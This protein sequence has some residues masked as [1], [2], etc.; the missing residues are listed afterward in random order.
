[1]RKNSVFEQVQQALGKPYSDLEFLL[2]CFEEVLVESNKQDIIQFIPWLNP[3]ACPS[4]KILLGHDYGHMLSMCFQLLNIVEVNGAVQG[5]RK[6]EEHHMSEVNGLWA[7]NFKVLKEKG[8]SE[9]QIM[10]SFQD[11]RIEPVL[12]AHPTEAKRS[13]VL[14]EYRMLY[15][16]MVKRENHMYTRIEQDDIREDIKQILHRL[17]NIDEIY[18]EKPQIESE[19]DNVIYYLKDVLPEVV[20]LLDKRLKQAWRE[21]GY[22]VDKLDQVDNIPGL[23]FGN[24][25]GGDRDG[26]PLVTAETTQMA[27]RKLRV[28]AFMIIKEALLDLAQKLSIYVTADQLSMDFNSRIAQLADEIGRDGGKVLKEHKNETFTAYILLLLNKIPIDL[29]LELNFKLLDKKGSYKNSLE[30]ID[31]INLL[32]Y[33]LI[34]F[35]ASKLA[36][37]DVGRFK[38]LLQV[39]GFHMARLDIRQNSAYHERA[40]FQLI[41]ASSLNG[42]DDEQVI[43]PEKKKKLIDKELTINRPFLV[44]H[45]NSG[46]EVKNVIECFQVLSKHVKKYGTRSMGKLIVSMTRNTEDLLTLFLFMRETG[47]T[48]KYNGEL[49]AKLPVVPLFETIEDLQNSPKI[50][51]EYLGHPVVKNSLK[52]QTKLNRAKNLAQDVMIGYSD[53]NKDGGILAS[54]WHLNKTQKQL[55]A[56]GKKHGVQV[57]FFHGTGGSISRGAGPSHWFIKSFPYGAIDGRFR[58]TEQG[59][60]IER[61]YANKVNAAYNLE[62]MQA[63]VATQ[64]ILHKYLPEPDFQVSELFEQLAEDGRK[65]Y[66][67]LIQDQDF[68]S[69][70]KEATPIDVIESSK[71]GSRPSRRTGK[72]SVEDLRAIPWVFSWAQARFNLT[73]WFGVGSA[74]QKM[75][76]N[77]SVQY[78]QLVELVK[79]EPF[80][81]YV[82]T[83]VDSSLAATDERIM[84]KYA[85]LVSDKTVRDK[86]MGQINNELKLTRQM[87]AD[88]LEKP[89]KER[90]TNHYYS[91]ILRAEAMES[92][93]EA[94]ILLLK[95]WRVNRA[96]NAPEEKENLFVLLQCVNAIANALG[97]TG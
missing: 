93:H 29:R 70:F 21:T 11:I 66:R 43:S 24:W 10:E 50:L 81:R 19:L 2:R 80:I 71:I 92:L 41:Q 38:R 35:G 1:M 25:V 51:D 83:N 62:L 87:L 4:E 58:V 91:T 86:I 36:H 17:W 31:D 34:R 56:I 60:T 46:E 44:D 28:N 33:E 63:S 54:T 30:L 61:K 39:F 65:Y 79:Y 84:E 48:E 53:S 82:F 97:S 42:N 7:A 20:P 88:I 73:S 75:K 15:L 72:Q 78:K 76:T 23:C 74:M 45:S 67:E 52:F 27:L 94:Q 69:F 26:H 22:D 49:A 55:S 89:F 16:L 59:E 12:T 6:K 77:N 57:R 32:Q 47:L 95:K 64:T 85:S 3:P 13:V 40:L 96:N 18:I 5:R 90:R 37:A 8:I 68:I 9:E 14:K